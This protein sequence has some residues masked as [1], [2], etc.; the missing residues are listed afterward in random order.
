LPADP[1]VHPWTGLWIC[2]LTLGLA[3]VSGSTTAENRAMAS[4]DACIATLFSGEETPRRGRRVDLAESCPDLARAL[5]AS[6]DGAPRIQWAVENLSEDPSTAELLD[7]KVLAAA[8]R[9]VAKLR[10]SRSPAQLREILQAVRLSEDDDQR[11]GWWDRFLGWLRD[12]VKRRSDADLGW[13]EG[14]L[15]AIQIEAETAN[16]ILYGV[17]AVLILSL[18][19]LLLSE[20]KAAGFFRSRRMADTG[21]GAWEGALAGRVPAADH[22]LG[23]SGIRDLAT[24]RQPA[25]ILRLCIRALIARGRL[26]DDPS[27]TNRELHRALA[28]DSTATSFGDLVV[29]AEGASYGGYQVTDQVLTRCYTGAEHILEAP[30]APSSSAGP[31]GGVI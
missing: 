4:L 2:A 11:L 29:L 23:L 9:D 20:L 6:A 22:D 13:L 26:P 1:K 12:L 19:A 15:D 5:R 24:Q 14:I 27:R 21:R 10:W 18:L 8:P 3:L 16:R 31:S 30:G 25:A 17:L 28:R 7:L